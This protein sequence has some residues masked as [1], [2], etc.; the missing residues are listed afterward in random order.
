MTQTGEGMPHRGLKGDWT[1]KLI[2]ASFWDQLD[3][4]DDLYYED[5]GVKPRDRIVVAPTVETLMAR[6]VWDEIH[7]GRRCTRPRA[8]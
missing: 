2:L 1:N 5:M 4:A 8:R 3:R 6:I 7:T